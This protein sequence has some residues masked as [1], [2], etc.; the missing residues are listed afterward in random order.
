MKKNHIASLESKLKGIAQFVIAEAARLG[1]TD[2][3]LSLSAGSSVE[4]EVRLAQVETLEGAQSLELT[5]RAFVGK[6]SASM[7]TTD[8][9][10]RALTKLVRETISMAREAQPDEFAGLPD[11]KYLARNVK[12]I[13]YMFDDA[14]AGLPVEK[15]IEMA[16]ALE[17]A[18]L[19]ADPRISVGRSTGFS[20]R[21]GYFLYANSRGFL[22][23]Y[24]SSYCTISTQVVARDDNGMQTGGWSSTSRHLAGLQSPEVVGRIAAER[25]LRQLNP[26][27]VSSQEVPVVFEPTMASRLIGQFVGAASGNVI[28][29]KRSFL[30]GKLGTKVAAAAVNIIDDGLIPGALG[31]RPF[32]GEGLPT[33]R[34]ILVGKGELKTYLVSS[35]A[36]RK[37]GCEP[38]G[39]GTTNLYMEAGEFSPEQ[40]IASVDNGLY[41]TSVSGPGFNSVTGDYSMGATG[42][43]IK[44]GKLTHAVEEI[45]IAGNILSMF[46]NIEMVG[47]DLVFRSSVNA[48]TIKIARMMVAGKAQG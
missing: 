26:L 14:L 6:G 34:R 38:N 9:R 13:D 8:L 44:D 41:L 1:A 5:F 29:Q 40:I 21:N 36:A 48:P 37:L 32:D 45:T 12:P 25:A 33:S 42:I 18:A 43:W 23:G 27:P 15:K 10:R 19:A 31:S 4:T 3:D 20:D 39:G 11:S 2:A 16:I 30:V 46:E 24:A 22:E 35:Y 17:K 28:Y 7:S 47:N